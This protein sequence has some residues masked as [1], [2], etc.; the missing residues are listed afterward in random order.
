MTEKGPINCLLFKRYL[1]AALPLLGTFMASAYTPLYNMYQAASSYGRSDYDD[2]Y[3]D[4]GY[5]R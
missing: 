4:D 3:Y 5:D 2:D 1:F